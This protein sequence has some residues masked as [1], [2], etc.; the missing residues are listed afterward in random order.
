M[1]SG[2]SSAVL[3]GERRRVAGVVE[4][5]RAHLAVLAGDARD[6]QRVVGGLVRVV[7][8]GEAAGLGVPEVAVHR[9]RA[10]AGAVRHPGG[11]ERRARLGD[12]AGDLRGQVLDV[13]LDQ[14]AAGPVRQLRVDVR[15]GVRVRHVEQER[16]VV[17]P[18][19]RPGSR[20]AGRSRPARA[21]TS[22][23][24][25]RRARA[26]A[27]R[28]R[29]ART[30]PPWPRTAGARPRRR[31]ASPR[32]RSGHRSRPAA[33]RRAWRRRSG[34]G[35]RGGDVHLRRARSRRSAGRW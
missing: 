5:R 18:G 9:E 20:L 23:G 27:R 13:R 8:A 16:G 26:S 25:P 14:L 2:E 6:E 32:P 19:L 30:R 29:A 10:A 4:D 15:A 34:S 22:R 35:W 31:R 17:E 33:S 12:R 24:R 21:G 11:R 1:K 3:P 28:P 7:A